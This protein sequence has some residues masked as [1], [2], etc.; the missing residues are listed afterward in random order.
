MHCVTVLP[1]TFWRLAGN[2]RSGRDSSGVLAE[3]HYN[4]A[5]ALRIQGRFQDALEHYAEA[6]KLKPDD[7]DT[8][9]GFGLTLAELERFDEAIRRYNRILELEP[10]NVIAHGLLGLA[11]AG[12]G[13]T[14]EAIEQFWIV[15]GQR[16]DDVEMCCNMGILLEQQGKTDEAINQYRRALQINP[17]YDKARSLLD[18]ALTKQNSQKQKSKGIV[19]TSCQQTA[20]DTAGK[21][22]Y[23]SGKFLV[24]VPNCVVEV[25]PP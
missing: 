10:G 12:Q 19:G 18:A 7:I 25:Y 15:L 4:L 1:H 13:K 17:A 3:A 2:Q 6:L 14:D 20:E 23:S 22:E 11:L 16:P 21:A 8:L 5:N 9:R 24:T